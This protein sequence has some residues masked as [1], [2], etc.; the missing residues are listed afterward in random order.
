M[1]G[2]YENGKFGIR[3]ENLLEVTYNKN[4]DNAAFSMG[5]REGDVDFPSKEEGKKRFLRFEKLTMIPIQ[6]NLIDHSL[7]TEKEFDW[8]NQ[9][10]QQVF[11]TISP[12]L[13]K[14]SLSWKWLKKSC[15]KIK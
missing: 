6:T 4:V 9:Y 3:I 15:E 10:H 14:Q 13:D 5:F 11:H 2:Y 7:M 8:I 1:G 12:H